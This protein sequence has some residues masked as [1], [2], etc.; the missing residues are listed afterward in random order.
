MSDEMSPNESLRAP[1][2]PPAEAARPTKSPVLAA[3]LTFLFPGVGQIYNGQATKA[4]VFF[5]A[6]VGSISLSASDQAMPFAFGIPFAFFY[7]LI[8]AYRSAVLINARRA[9]EPL[10]SAEE[11]ASPAWGF[12]LIGLGVVL[13]LN[14]LGWLDLASLR[15]FWPILLIVAGGLIVYGA[16]KRRDGGAGSGA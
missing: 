10:E 3:A 2:L 8:D 6:F 5:A 7:S 1:A 4:L 16:V 15:R 12:T 13:L 14:N 9:G 11:P